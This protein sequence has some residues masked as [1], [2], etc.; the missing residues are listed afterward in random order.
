MS[1]DGNTIV[2]GGGSAGEGLK[3]YDVRN[4]AEPTVK[5]GWK[6]LSN[7][8]VHN[9]LFNTVKIVPKNNLLLAGG[10]DSTPAKCFSLLTG[11]VWEKF[12]EPERSCMTISISRDAS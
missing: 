1:Q 2:V 7:D 6:L 9:P 5:I 12:A 3:V 4:L 8:H 10:C 11:E